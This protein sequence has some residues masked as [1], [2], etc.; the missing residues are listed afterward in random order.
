MRNLYQHYRFE[1]RCNYAV[2]VHKTGIT[3]G[4]SNTTLTCTTDELLCANGLACYKTKFQCDGFNDCDDY[5]D[6]AGCAGRQVE[7]DSY[8]FYCE[9]ENDCLPDLYLCDGI[10]DCPD[11][12]DESD[13][14]LIFKNFKHKLLLVELS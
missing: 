12:S 10:A 9:T 7:C 3:A 11:G 6:E 5:S 13:C 4:A 2:H 14:E 8:E 1:M